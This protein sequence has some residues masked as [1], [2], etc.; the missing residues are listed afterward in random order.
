MSRVPFPGLRWARGER[1]CA[2]PCPGKP[3][4]GAGE[5]WVPPGRSPPAPS[6]SGWWDGSSSWG[7]VKHGWCRAGCKPLGLGAEGNHSCPWL[8][9][10]L[11]DVAGGAPRLRPHPLETE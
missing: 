4:R 8:L 1:G 11:P 9:V 10:L 2:S 7:L 5:S 6:T 3:Q